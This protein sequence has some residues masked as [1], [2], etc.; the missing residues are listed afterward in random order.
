MTSNTSFVLPLLLGLC[1]CGGSGSSGSSGSSGA[2]QTPGP[3]DPVRL[4]G[5]GVVANVLC[6]D[7][8]AVSASGTWDALV[9]GSGGSDDSAVIT[10]DGSNFV[11][12]TKES[13]LAFAVNGA[14][15][16]LTWTDGTK[17]PAA[18]GVT[19]AAS[20]VDLGVLPLSMGGQW[21]FAGNTATDTCTASFTGTAFNVGCVKAEMAVGRIDGALSGIRQQE[22]SS[23]FGA[24]GGVWHLTSQGGSGSVDATIS[25]NVLT[26]VE[27]RASSKSSPYWFTMKLCNAAASG[28]TSEGVEIAATRR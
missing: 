26:A 27:N 9:S 3:V 24:L 21:T 22:K 28:K 4:P 12:T 17:A 13:T 25:G 7:D 14:A 15:M 23:V 6:G 19:R 18:T 1:A 10:L 20:A 5:G 2:T 11:V 8:S 16:T